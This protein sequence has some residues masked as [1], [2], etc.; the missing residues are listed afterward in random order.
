MSHIVRFNRPQRGRPS[1]G[2]FDMSPLSRRSMVPRPVWILTALMILAPL[3]GC[4]S[5]SDSSGGDNEGEYTWIDPV[6]EIEDGNLS[7]IHI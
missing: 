2:E 6:T 4:L 1:Q 5:F 7:L 3:S